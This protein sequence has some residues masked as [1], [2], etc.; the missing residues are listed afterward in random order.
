MKRLMV[1]ILA[2]VVCTSFA[3]AGEQNPYVKGTWKVGYGGVCFNKTPNPNPNCSTV[4]PE[5]VYLKEYKRQGYWIKTIHNGN[6]GFVSHYALISID[7][8]AKASIIVRHISSQRF[9][10]AYRHTFAIVNEGNAEWKGK[11]VIYGYVFS[12]QVF[13]EGF[14]GVGKAYIDTNTD[15]QTWK[16]EESSY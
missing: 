8:D 9:G 10:Q 1:V 3:Y 12:K 5:G 7:A 15:F 11:V 6:V 13:R 2:M 16:Y 14:S 4:I